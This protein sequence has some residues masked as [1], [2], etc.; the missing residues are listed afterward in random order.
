MGRAPCCDKANVKKGPWSPEEDAKLKSYIEQHGTGGNW[1]ALPQ[2]IGSCSDTPALMINTSMRQELQAPVAELPPAQHQARRVLRGRGSDHLQPLH[3]HRQ[4]QRVKDHALPPLPRRAGLFGRKVEAK[5]ETAEHGGF[6]S[7]ASAEGV[8]RTGAVAGSFWPDPTAPAYGPGHCDAYAGE[9][10]HVSM[11]KLLLK[12]GGSY[13]APPNALHP[14]QLAQL[15]DDQT[16]SSS[17]VAPSLQVSSF[18][19]EGLILHGPNGFQTELDEIFHFN[20]V[21]LEGLDDCIYEDE[22]TNMLCSNAPQSMSWNDQVSPNL[23][24]PNGVFQS[25]QGMQQCVLEEPV[26]LGMQ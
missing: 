19:Q 17:L 4:Q 5:A 9:D 26:R 14:P 12:L 1:I 21:K 13:I 11:R 15:Y 16:T 6:G 23:M 18:E 3:Q 10:C 22:S 24:F 20:Q 8:N 7:M 25:Y 2:K